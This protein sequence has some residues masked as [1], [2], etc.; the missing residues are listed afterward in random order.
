MRGYL[1]QTEPYDAN[2]LEDLPMGERWFRDLTNKD[3]RIL[4]FSHFA[5]RKN[6][7]NACQFLMM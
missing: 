3:I 5:T 6:G 2:K 4:R 1:Y 7:D